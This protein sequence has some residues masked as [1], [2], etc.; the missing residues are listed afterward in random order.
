M[1]ILGENGT[2]K[3]VVAQLLHD[4]L[5]RASSDAGQGQHGRHSRSGV[6]ERRCSATCAA[7]SPTPRADRIGRFELA[8]GGTLFLDEIAN[9]PVAQQPKLLRV[10]ED[11]ELERVGSSRTLKVDVRV[12]SATNADLAA[13]VAGGAFRKDLLFRLNT[14]SCACRR[15][16]N[17]ATISACS[18][19]P[20]SHS[21]RSATSATASLCAVGDC[22]VENYPWPG[23]VR[24]LSHV[25]RARGADG[26]RRCRRRNHAQP[27]RRT[28]AVGRGDA[29]RGSESISDGRSRRGATRTPGTGTHRRQYPA[30]GRLARPSRP[31]LSTHGKIRH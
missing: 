31:P 15:C 28:V 10:L 24:E 8:D 1:L 5:G 29:R 19:N 17:A 26:G 13:E 9:I 4:A 14:L 11:G 23:N 22:G 27:E 25:D 6:R 20:F 18:P 7:P 21:S 30:R 16:A 3:G 12:I 2:G